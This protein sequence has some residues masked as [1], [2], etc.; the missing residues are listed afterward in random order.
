MEEIP[1]PG[2]GSLRLEEGFSLVPALAVRPS[3]G[4]VNLSPTPDL[5][6]Q[7]CVAGS[8]WTPG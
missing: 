8:T 6:S 4:L 1:D 2:E 5:D 7:A 3:E